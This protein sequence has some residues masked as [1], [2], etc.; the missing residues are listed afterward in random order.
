[1]QIPIEISYHNVDGSQW[2]EDY[3]KERAEHL[4]HTCGGLV[5]CRVVIEKTQHPHHTGNPFRVRVEATMPPRKVLIGDKEDIVE[6]THI[7]LRPII[8]HAF[9]AAEKQAKKQKQM[10]RGEVKL[11]HAPETL[12][13]PRPLGELRDM[14]P[15]GMVVRLCRE[16]PWGRGPHGKLREYYQQFRQAGRLIQ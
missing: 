12:P 16:V 7:Q 13:E 1:M 10:L 2:L 9:D 4:E 3:V 5:S 14:E 6:D 11:H 15:T 8:R